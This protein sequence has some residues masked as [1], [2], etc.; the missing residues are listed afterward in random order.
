MPCMWVKWPLMY[1]AL[2]GFKWL[3]AS[4]TQKTQIAIK[5]DSPHQ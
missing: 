2:L 3:E 4:L 1:Q 5:E